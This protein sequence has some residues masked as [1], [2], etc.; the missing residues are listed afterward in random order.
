MKKI[1]FTF[2]TLFLLLLPLRAWG[3]S[4]YYCDCTVNSGTSG[5]GTFADPFESINAIN[6]AKSGFSAGDDV[7]FLAGSTCVDSERLSVTWTGSSGNRVIIGGYDGDGDF[8]ITGSARPILDG[9]GTVP[10]A[11]HGLIE[12]FGSS[13]NY[14]TVQDLYVDNSAAIGILVNYADYITIDNC[15]VNNTTNSG[16]MVAR[17]HDS[18]VQYCIVSTIDGGTSGGIV[19][20]GMDA[21]NSCYNCIVRHCRVSNHR[22]ESIGANKL[23]RD[24]VIEYNVVYDGKNVGIYMDGSKDITVRFNLVYSADGHPLDANSVMWLGIGVECEQERCDQYPAI[25]P[26]GSGHEIYGNLISGCTYGIGILTDCAAHNWSGLLVYNNTV[27]DCDYNISIASNQTGWSGNEIRNNLSVNYWGSSNECLNCS[28]TTGITWSHNVWDGTVTGDAA[29]GSGTVLNAT[30]ALSKTSNWRSVAEGSLDGTEFALG[31]GSSAIDVGTDLGI[32]YA[33]G[34]DLINTDFSATPPSVITLKHGD[35]GAG[36]DIGAGV[37]QAESEDPPANNDCSAAIAHYILDAN[38]ED[39][40]TNN[41][42]LTA[43]ASPTYDGAGIVLNGSSQYAHITNLSDD[44]A[45][46]SLFVNFKFDSA[47]G[48]GEMDPI[49][50][51]WDSGDDERVFALIVGDAIGAGAGDD[52]VRFQVGHTDG[53][54]G[55]FAILE[56]AYALSP[57]TQ[58]S[59]LATYD[60]V[61]DDAHIYIHNLSGTILN[62]ASG[63]TDATLLDANVQNVEATPFVLGAYFDSDS[64]AAYY[65]GTIYE[66]AVYDSEK[67]QADGQAFSTFEYADASAITVQGMSSACG[68][69]TSAGTMTWAIGWDRESFSE[70]T[71]WTIPATFDYPVAAQTMTYVGKWNDQTGWVNHTGDIWKKITWIEPTSVKEDTNVMTEDDGN[72]ATLAADKWDWDNTT[73]TT[74]YLYVNVGGDPSSSVITPTPWETYVA[75]ATLA[76]WRQDSF[77]DA[78]IGDD[79]TVT[80]SLTDAQDEDAVITGALSGLGTYPS[81]TVAIPKP[82]TA[83]WTIGSGKDYATKV[84][85]DAAIAEVDNDWIDIYDLTENQD[86]SDSGTSGNPIS[87]RLRGALTGT[88]EVSGDYTNV[89]NSGRAVSSTRTDSGSN[90]NWYSE[91]PAGSIGLSMGMGLGGRKNVTDTP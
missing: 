53:A 3:A 60:A 20:T 61:N 81:N 87:I 64:P 17:S 8:D 65:D 9:N 5:A 57:D 89:Y 54:T 7:Y 78:Q 70:G 83:P 28:S 37:F 42:D 26:Y 35:Y 58:Y 75:I 82:H 1:L 13:Y 49:C 44:I 14:I 90:N 36:W 77:G 41:N 74:P 39:S 10:G 52:F 47:F 80:G 32:A 55:E 19:L 56:S 62:G 18:I 33:D 34:L 6:D 4:P 12:I 79:I 48:D 86:W 50:G 67:S 22:T 66:V 24:C 88:F 63:E 16:I 25:Y 21:L 71:P 23:A 69:I 38:V 30:P 31:S 11:E 2:L 68:N 51:E 46:I 45:S 40:T 29:A 85:F 43:V 73:P 15:V 59:I 76:G 27:V 84:A 91:T 72:F